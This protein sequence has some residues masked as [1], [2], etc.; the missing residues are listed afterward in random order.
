[1]N[2]PRLARPASRPR[3]TIEP[4]RLCTTAASRP[5]AGVA[6]DRP[7]SIN[8]SFYLPQAGAFKSN[9]GGGVVEAP[10]PVPV[11]SGQVSVQV[12]VSVTYLIK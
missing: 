4:P 8:E 7:Y 2:A 3:L 12:D 11:Q 10:A 9:L 5:T 1:M 6:I